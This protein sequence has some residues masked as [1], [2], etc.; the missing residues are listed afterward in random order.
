MASYPL[1][2]PSVPSRPPLDLGVG[3]FGG[4]QGVGGEMFGP[5][6]LMRSVSGAAETDKPMVVELAVAAM[7]EL[8]RMAQLNEPLWIPAGLDNATEA[9]NE[10]EYVRT[11]PRGIGPRPF[12]LKSEASRETAVVI[13]NQMNVVE[14]LMDVVRKVAVLAG[15]SEKKARSDHTCA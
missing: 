10:E 7:E 4:Q 15:V 11:F 6:E 3:G 1:L 2:S 14:I 12:G 9:L 8:I 13:M 5:G